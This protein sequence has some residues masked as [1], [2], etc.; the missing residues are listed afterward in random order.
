MRYTRTFILLLMILI[1]GSLNS[2]DLKRHKWENRLV[3]ILTDNSRDVKYLNQ[4]IEF[5]NNKDGIKERK[6]LVYHITPEKYKMGLSG[7]EWQKLETG[8]KRYKKTDA[9]P[10]IILI[11][12]DG[13]IK[14]RATEFISSQKLFATIDVMPMR[15][16]EIKRKR[17]QD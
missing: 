13:G 4:V 12:L 17:N 1:T 5:K 9:Q 14:L 7:E 8:Y 6:I 15:M 10:E 3:L 11:G 2:Q 16:Q